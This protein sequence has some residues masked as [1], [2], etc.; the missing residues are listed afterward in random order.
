MK[1]SESNF[2]LYLFG[3]NVHLVY[4]L[5]CCGHMAE[6]CAANQVTLLRSV[7]ADTMSLL[8]FF[9][10]IWL[11]LTAFVRLFTKIVPVTS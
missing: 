4:M 6:F 1:E 8:L 9:S 7:E 3:E 2:V 11:A 5:W 10:T